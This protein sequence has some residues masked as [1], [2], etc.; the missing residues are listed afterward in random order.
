M[1]IITGPQF[2]IVVPEWWIGQKHQCELCGTI[3]TF[4]KES[5]VEVHNDM[6]R[7]NSYIHFKCPKCTKSGCQLKSLKEFRHPI[8]KLIKAE[9]IVEIVEKPKKPNVFQKLLGY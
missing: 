1:D 9:I 7:G 8:K 2:E 4:T 3:W 6:E 5:F